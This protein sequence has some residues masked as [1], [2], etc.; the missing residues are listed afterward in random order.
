MNEQYI[1]EQTPCRA[2]IL[3]E[4]RNNK[5]ENKQKT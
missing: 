2:Y 1:N 3:L 4:E 5:P